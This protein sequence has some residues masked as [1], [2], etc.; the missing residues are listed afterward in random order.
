MGLATGN[1]RLLPTDAACGPCL[2]LYQAV[3]CD[4][5]FFSFLAV[6]QFWAVGRDA[7][8]I[9]TA[10]AR[11]TLCAVASSV[12]YVG[13]DAVPGY[14]TCLSSTFAFPYLP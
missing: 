11:A 8:Y 5:C 3:R 7:S 6:H 13:K 14:R 9:I 10:L 12:Q 4:P 2:F 1:N